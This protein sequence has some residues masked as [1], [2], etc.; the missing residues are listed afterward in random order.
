MAGEDFTGPPVLK[1]HN[2]VN[3][4][5]K[6]PFATPSNA[7]LPRNIG[8]LSARAPGANK[9]IAAAQTYAWLLAFKCIASNEFNS[10][11]LPCAGTVSFTSAC[12][13]N[14]NTYTY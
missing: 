1:L 6:L 11:Y 14:K 5:A 9:H 10:G 2:K 3:F 7:G 12:R 8:Q 13:A 4:G